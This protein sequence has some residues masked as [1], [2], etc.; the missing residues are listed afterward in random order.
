M[1]QPWDVVRDRRLFRGADCA[2]GGGAA[3]VLGRAGVLNESTIRTRRWRE[4]SG[5]ALDERYFGLHHDLPPEMI[6]RQLGGDL[7]WKRDDDRDGMWIALI[8]FNRQIEARADEESS[9][10]GNGAELNTR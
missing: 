7:V 9:E 1:K 4:L 2:R 3:G 8:R 5:E 10:Q 6:A